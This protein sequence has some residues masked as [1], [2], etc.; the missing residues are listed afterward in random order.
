MKSIISGFNDWQRSD[1]ERLKDLDKKQKRKD[2][3]EYGVS[4]ILFLVFIVLTILFF[5]H[6]H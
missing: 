2:A 4:I 1:I 5:T 3:I 6:K